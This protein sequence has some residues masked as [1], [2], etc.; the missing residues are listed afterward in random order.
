M[1]DSSAGGTSRGGGY[2][3]V[4]IGALRVGA[5]LRSP[6]Y[7]D[8]DDRDVLLLA[9]GTTITSPVLV[10]LKARN[11]TRVRVAAADLSSVASPGPQ[12]GNHDG[13]PAQPQAAARRMSGSP[14]QKSSRPGS[15]NA[16]PDRAVSS[17]SNSWRL[18]SD[19]FIHKV[20]RHG[21]ES[22]DSRTK[23]QFVHDYRQSVAQIDSM[24]HSL[25]EGS[26]NN[27]DAIVSMSKDSLGKIAEDGDLFVSLGI[28]PRSDRYPARHSLQTATLAMAIGT[29]LGLASQALNELGIGCLVH[30]VG[31]LHVDRDLYEAKRV[32]DCIEFLEITKHPVLTFDLIRHLKAIPTGSRMV[33]YQMHER[34]DGSGYPRQRRGVQ[35]HHLARVA[36][37]ADVFVASISP[38]PHRP[39]KLPYVAMEHLIQG[40][41]DQWFDPAAVRGLL[42][43]VSLFP[44]GSYVEMQDGR[45]GRVIRANGDDY[46]RPIV[47]L[48]DSDNMAAKPTVVDLS[49]ETECKVARPLAELNTMQSFDCQ[50]ETAAPGASEGEGILQP[51]AS[52][53]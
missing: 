12:D 22:Y 30:D 2:A 51:T 37:V 11:I 31:M 47:E 49:A 27:A 48:W 19:S 43:T 44:I 50:P 53:G 46:A 20:R 33:A 1:M 5:T 42:K 32:L 24:F 14:R 45:V 16:A 52:H 29:N 9:S 10:R 7:D 28:E 3:P 38:R 39:G 4:G 13:P 25:S 26:L 41:R 8:R 40:T 23:E 35:I 15:P 18:S 21:C 6:I 17:G 34:Y 36:A